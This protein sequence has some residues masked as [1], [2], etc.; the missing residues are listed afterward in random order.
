MMEW[1]EVEVVHVSV[2]RTLNSA[3]GRPF[4]SYRYIITTVNYI[5]EYF[6]IRISLPTMCA[7]VGYLNELVSQRK[8]L[9]DNET[10][11][12]LLQ[13]FAASYVPQR[14]IFIGTWP[15]FKKISSAHTS[16]PSICL[17]YIIIT[18][19]KIFDGINVQVTTRQ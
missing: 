4:C 6:N 13:K 11:A 2:Q 14:F 5:P 17:T 8:I 12:Q 7:E 19:I 1:F 3:H 9:H 16:R 18:V 15:H 10:L